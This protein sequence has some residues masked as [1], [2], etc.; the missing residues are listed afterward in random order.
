M[1]EVEEKLELGAFK[2]TEAVNMKANRWRKRKTLSPSKQ[3]R[4]LEALP[5]ITD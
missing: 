4:K 2:R 5:P 1:P 3:T